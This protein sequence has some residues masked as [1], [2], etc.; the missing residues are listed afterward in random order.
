MGSPDAEA[1]AQAARLA[2]ERVQ[3]W[4]ADDRLDA[5]TAAAVAVAVLEPMENAHKL[6][7][8]SGHVPDVGKSQEI[9]RRAVV[10]RHWLREQGYDIP[11]YDKE[12]GL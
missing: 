9:R 11:T 7:M 1:R 6:A 10:T 5:E 4:Q 2:K 3:R 8:H 12:P